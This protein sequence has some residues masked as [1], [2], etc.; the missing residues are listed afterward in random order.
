MI[1]Y[2]Q[3]GK[4]DTDEEVKKENKNAK[5]V[6]RMCR[7]KPEQ[8]KE[9]TVGHIIPLGAVDNTKNEFNS[10]YIIIAYEIAS[11]FG[12]QVNDFSEINLYTRESQ[13]IAVLSLE[14]GLNQMIESVM[15]KGWHI[16]V[17][18]QSFKSVLDELTKTADS[19]AQLQSASKTIQDIVA[20]AIDQM[21]KS[22]A[23]K[24]YKHDI[25]D[26]FYADCDTLD[27]KIYKI[28]SS[29]DNQNEQQNEQQDA[30]NKMKI[31]ILVYDRYANGIRL[32]TNYESFASTRIRQHEA[33]D[34]KVWAYVLKARIQVDPS[35]YVQVRQFN[36]STTIQT[37]NDIQGCC[38]RIIYTLVN[39]NYT[40][41]N[42]ISLP[43][44]DKHA[45]Q[46]I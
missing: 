22:Q 3:T 24:P 16:A 31:E 6:E 23:E 42:F 13:D 26:L 45:Y 21:K 25:I 2:T 8:V 38:K 20:R 1:F 11:D 36:G 7:E 14:N 29:I 33:D 17:F 43:K 12:I 40:R 32:L 5:I 30:C 35:D 15:G 44:G 28:K 41:W 19:I 10:K 18:N 9:Y 34:E 4:F 37:K 27:A 46:V 39:K